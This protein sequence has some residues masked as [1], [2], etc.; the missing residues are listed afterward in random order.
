[1]TIEFKS[2]LDQVLPERD[3]DGGWGIVDMANAVSIVHPRGLAED[4]LLLQ[5]NATFQI[6]TRALE[7][8]RAN[9]ERGLSQLVI[10]WDS[11]VL[12]IQW[13]V[14]SIR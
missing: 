12:I 3:R 5:M 8:F 2:D 4:S 13:S 1:M 11:Q 10:I 7:G 9:L 6:S 14:S